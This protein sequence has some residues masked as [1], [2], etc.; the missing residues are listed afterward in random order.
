MSDLVARLAE[1]IPEI[2]ELAVQAVLR[3][4]PYYHQLP[5]AA[6]EVDVREIARFNLE[7]FV[8]GIEQ[9]RPPTEQE[10]ARISH[11]ASR[12]AQEGIPLGHVLA[13]NYIGTRA[14]WEAVAAMAGPS[15]AADVSRLGSYVIDYLLLLSQ[16]VTDGYIETTMA[17]AGHDQQARAELIEAVAADREAPELWEKAGLQPWRDRTVVALRLAPPAVGSDITIAVD[18]RRRNREIREALS[19]AGP[20][21]DSLSA[22]GGIVLLSGRFSYERL[23][24]L[25]Q[26]LMTAN[27]AG[28]WSCT[29]VPADTGAAIQAA[30]EIA[31]VAQRLKFPPAVYPLTQVLFQ[32]QVT[33]PGPARTALLESLA[34]VE[35][36]TPTFGRLYRR[37]WTAAGIAGNVR[38]C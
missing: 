20:I 3:E 14:C 6:I 18:G 28:G 38:G 10:I 27:W 9:S 16:A 35:K 15:E 24:A 31:E 30:T 29:D 1:R 26:P 12:R 25:I 7:L 11:S 4:L 2:T 5:P 22:T 34:V 32:V 8:R 17:V 13:A 21:L 36:K 19:V 37:I 33:R 23:T